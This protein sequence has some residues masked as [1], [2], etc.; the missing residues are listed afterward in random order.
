MFEFAVHGLRRY[1]RER[2]S[3]LLARRSQLLEE[4]HTIIQQHINKV[5]ETVGVNEGWG[6]DDKI[7]VRAEDVVTPVNITTIRQYTVYVASDA[8]H[9]RDIIKNM[10]KY[11]KLINTISMASL[12]V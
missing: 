11:V 6:Q 9:V 12:S 4:H 10:C 5:K 7:Q 3:L 2:N 1:Q 8:V